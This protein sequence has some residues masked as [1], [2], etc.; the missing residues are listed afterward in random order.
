MIKNDLEIRV[1]KPLTT[2]IVREVIWNWKW[3]RVAALVAVVAFGAGC[4]GIRASH[5]ISPASFF[6]PGL[7][8]YEAP[9]KQDSIPA[10]S[11][12]EMLAQK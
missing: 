12:G 11:P 9:T 7:L 5:S 6:L 2:S 3:I 1:A 8:K 4:G 10:A